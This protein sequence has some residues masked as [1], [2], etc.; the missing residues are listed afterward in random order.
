MKKRKSLEPLRH[1]LQSCIRANQWEPRLK[2]LEVFDLW[3]G[4][5]GDQIAKN[6]TPLG[7][8]NGV[9]TVQVA[10]S[11]WLNEL[12]FQ[13][14]GM[15]RN[16]NE[17]LGSRIIQDIEFKLTTWQKAPEQSVSKTGFND[18]VFLGR[19]NL[20]LY[21]V[22]PEAEELAEK[23]AAHLTDEKLK[24]ALKQVLITHSRMNSHLKI[25]GYQPCVHCGT[26]TAKKSGECYFCSRKRDKNYR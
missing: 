2:E 10:S 6:T 19:V 16:L 4:C 17:K 20:G 1:S 24:A 13:K 18:R 15:I 11:P 12:K 21:P 22:S 3:K 25:K 23:T 14:T 7:V 5:V 9:L 26:L 8:R